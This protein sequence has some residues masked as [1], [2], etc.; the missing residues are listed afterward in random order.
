MKSGKYRLKTVFTL[1][2]KQNKIEISM[3]AFSGDIS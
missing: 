1:T 2:D 3:I